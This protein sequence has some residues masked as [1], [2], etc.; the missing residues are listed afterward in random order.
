MN[1]ITIIS[2][3]KENIDWI[4]DIKTHYIVY[5]KG[6]E[7]KGPNIKNIQNIGTEPYGYL[8]YIID[9]YSNL[10]DKIIFTQGN[11]FPHSP[12]FLSLLEKIH[13]F[14]DIQPLTSCYNR[15]VPRSYIRDI[16]SSYL[17]IDNIPIHIEF[18]DN[19]FSTY[20]QN[21]IYHQR[22]LKQVHKILSTFFGDSNVRDNIMNFIPIKPREFNNFKITPFCYSA[23][24]CVSKEKI[25]RYPLSFYINLKNKCEKLQSTDYRIFG[26]IMEYSWMEMFGYNPP[27]ELVPTKPL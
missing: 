4:K 14:D 3:F 11:P 7:I 12:H 21:K 15:R 17:K 26:W 5:N 16:S 13:K 18:Y 20:L 24:F 9:N 1:S 25:L 27:N 10:P 19:N 6:D 2:R 23:I 22:P 8:L